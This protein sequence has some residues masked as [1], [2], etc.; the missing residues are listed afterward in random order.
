[1][2]LGF[3]AHGSVEV[4]KRFLEAYGKDM[5]FCLFQV[6]DMDWHFQNAEEK[7]A[8]AGEYNLPIWVRELLRGGKLATGIPKKLLYQN[9][10][11]NS[12]NV[13]ITT[14]KFAIMNR[15][16]PKAPLQIMKRGF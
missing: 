14:K 7:M 2:H 5:E 6:N 4:I 16:L 9:I 8:L 15:E 3:S 12:T 13:T 11:P 1:M 10:T